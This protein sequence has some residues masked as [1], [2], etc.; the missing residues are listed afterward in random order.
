MPLVF[1]FFFYFGYLFL[2][3]V[4]F[5]FLS[6]YHNTDRSHWFRE[7]VQWII[8]K[9]FRVVLIIKIGSTISSGTFLLNFSFLPVFVVV[10]IGKDVL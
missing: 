2:F 1:I 4:P 6:H 9:V 8:D 10:F 3:L 5:E 7:D